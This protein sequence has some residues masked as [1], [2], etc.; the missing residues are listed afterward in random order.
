M[1]DLSAHA[2]RRGVLALTA[3]LLPMAAEARKRRRKKKR[4]DHAA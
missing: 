2:T 4:R 1:L 3:S